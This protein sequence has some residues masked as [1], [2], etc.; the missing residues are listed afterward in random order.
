M[1]PVPGYEPVL[2]SLTP[3]SLIHPSR[4]PGSRVDLDEDLELG[5][6]LAPSFSLVRGPHWPQS[7]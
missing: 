3:L 6:R 4:I 2:R 1:L 7:I 5:P